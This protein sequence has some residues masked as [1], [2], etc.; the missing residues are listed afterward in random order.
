MSDFHRGLSESSEVDFP[1]GCDPPSPT[2][3]L[4]LY[5]ATRSSPAP[6]GPAVRDCDRVLEALARRAL[7]TDDTIRVDGRVDT[8]GRYLVQQCLPASHRDWRDAPWDRRRI[9]QVLSRITRDLHVELAARS[10]TALTQL[11]SYVASR[12][13]F[14]LAIDDFAPGFDLDDLV[15]ASRSELAAVTERY[16]RGEITDGE[17]YNRCVDSWALTTE[18]ARV[19]ARRCAPALDPL[20]AYASSLVFGEPPERL[21]TMIGLLAAGTGEV[22]ERP[23][24]GTRA[25][26]L[27]GH[28]YFLCS[29]VAGDHRHAVAE[30]THL[31]APLS[32]ALRADLCGVAIVEHD[33]GTTEG[34]LVRALRHECM[35]VASLG[36][37][38]E[39]RVVV[40]AVTAP[41]GELIAPAGALI[42]P[43]LAERIDAAEVYSV[44][45][46]DVLACRAEGGV[47][48][49][50]FG[51]APE[52][53]I[54][55]VVGDPVGSRAAETIARALPQF[56]D[57]YFGVC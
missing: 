28:E 21:R 18:R 5:L 6:R 27:D 31:A 12:S 50:C 13:G 10:A 3:C 23:V 45:V 48:A 19:E 54:W 30:R 20:T 11:G 1:L 36:E 22:F 15:A 40:E 9:A 16:A 35:P 51:L 34:S 7:T 14:S 57:H 17:R 38:I 4:G 25:K 8:V 26:G 32:N 46:R 47:C 24:L 2:A 53:A 37:R 56:S 29:L 33:C 55:P 43:A 49:V 52:D 39:G 42:T 41:A 44:V